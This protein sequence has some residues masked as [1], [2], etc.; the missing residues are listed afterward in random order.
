MTDENEND[1]VQDVPTTYV[2]RIVVKRED[3]KHSREYY[4][5]VKAW[6][7]KKHPKVFVVDDGPLL[8]QGA[9]IWDVY[10]DDTISFFFTTK[11]LYLEFVKEFPQV[12]RGTE[13]ES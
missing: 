11:E 13:D 7:R 2:P 12:L 4:I 8:K 1:I 5:K 9:T 10:E 3:F 6:C